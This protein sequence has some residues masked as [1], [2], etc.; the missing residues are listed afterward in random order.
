MD[1]T[2]TIG[3][4]SCIG[5]WLGGIFTLITL[6][7]FKSI[8][9]KPDKEIEHLAAIS[10]SLKE[11]ERTVTEKTDELHKIGQR[12]HKL[13]TWTKLHDDQMIYSENPVTEIQPRE[14]TDD[15]LVAC[16][17]QREALLQHLNICKR[18]LK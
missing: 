15:T 16:K 11:I 17:L 5:I 6:E 18:H 7:T 13:E 9:S 8:L 14:Q 10:H 4:A 1:T 2:D 12:L 3:L